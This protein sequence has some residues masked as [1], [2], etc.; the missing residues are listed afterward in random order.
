MIIEVFLICLTV[1]LLCAPMAYAKAHE[2]RE[3]AHR[4]EIEND[5]FDF[6]QTNKESEGWQ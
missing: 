3:R 1:F 6:N 5:E 2:I 4:L